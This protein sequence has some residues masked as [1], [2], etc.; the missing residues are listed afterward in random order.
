MMIVIMYIVL[1]SYAFGCLWLI[2]TWSRIK[3]KK[4]LKTGIVL[5]F[6]SIIIP[7]RN[8]E[9]NLL[10]LLQDIEKQSIES[11]NFEVIIVN[12]ASTDSTKAVAESFIRAT[13]CTVSLINLPS[14]QENSSPKKRAITMA[15]QIA[16]GELIVT[17]DGDC[18]V[19]K[20]WLEEISGC[21][22]A[23]DSVLISGPV[24]FTDERQNG[25]LRNF[26]NALQ[27]IEFG[28]LVGTAAC[29]I[30]AGNP[31]MCSGA[32][33]AYKK[34]AFYSVD[35]YVGNEQIA[36]GDDEFLMHKLAKRF[37]GKIQFLKSR[38]AIVQTEG[39]VSFRSFYQQRKR[40]ASKWRFYNDW[41]PTALAIYVV[42]V[43]IALL[44]AVIAGRWELV[45]FK[46][47]FEWLFLMQIM[48][49]MKKSWTIP[50]I[51]IAQ[52]F[53]PFYVLFFAVMAQDSG[54]YVWKE[55]QLK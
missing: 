39:H 32:N 33:L 24:T 16:K 17:T 35:G 44:W 52:L 48:E 25:F 38:K 4:S 54:S 42:L 29:A 45:L 46:F 34:S 31:N 23:T 51:F 53:Y 1:L 26:F 55:R 36:S 2:V 7:V 30:K 22:L 47:A 18:R 27:I 13:A 9:A 19:G 20:Q 8:E 5:P 3:A 28:S 21:Y 49:F 41:K 12:D 37:P 14:V 6:I 50:Y 40:W 15:V 43:N 10:K 11:Q